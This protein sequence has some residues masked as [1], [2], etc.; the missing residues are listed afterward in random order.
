MWSFFQLFFLKA[1]FQASFDSSLKASCIFGGKV[2]LNE[3]FRHC[4][5]QAPY[6]TVQN[7][8]FL[9][10]KC[11][12]MRIRVRKCRKCKN[13]ENHMVLLHFQ[14]PSTKRIEN[15][16]YY[17][18]CN[19]WYNILLRPNNRLLRPKNRLLRLNDRLLRPNNRLLRPNNPIIEAQ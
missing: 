4:G 10:Q 17:R 9:F 2:V 18:I 11:N 3:H 6:K 12:L 7:M 14:R 16:I 19:I 8:T 13:Y 1:T 5:N 15:I